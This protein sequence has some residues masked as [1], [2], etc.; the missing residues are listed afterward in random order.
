MTDFSAKQQTNDWH[1]RGEL[2]PVGTACQ[3]NHSALGWIDC[4]IIAHHQGRAVCVARG[5]RLNYGTIRSFKPAK[6]ERERVASELVDVMMAV[7]VSDRKTPSE[8]FMSMALA[9][10]DHLHPESRV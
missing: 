7:P 2:P 5:D 8:S 9:I 6:S 10:Y 3:Y 1:K 4:E